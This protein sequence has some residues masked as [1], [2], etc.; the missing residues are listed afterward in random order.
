[1][2]WTA[3]RIG[4]CPRG[5]PG[6]RV[7]AYCSWIGLRKAVASRHRNLKS[8]SGMSIDNDTVKFRFFSEFYLAKRV[9]A[10]MPNP[11]HE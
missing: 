3:R 4:P 7:S 5:P 6:G 10:P 2:R 1:M 8:L 11:A 9:Q